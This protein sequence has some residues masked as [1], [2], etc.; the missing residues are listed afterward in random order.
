MVTEYGLP[1]DTSGG[2]TGFEPSVERRGIHT[3]RTRRMPRRYPFHEA[4]EI[5]DRDE[6]ESRFKETIA[7]NSED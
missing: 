2:V 6:G 4:Q 5:K 7:V 3:G 1:T